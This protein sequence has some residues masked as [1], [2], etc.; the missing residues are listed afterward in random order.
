MYFKCTRWTYRQRCHAAPAR[1][2]TRENA[3]FGTEVCGASRFRPSIM[4]LCG[5]DYTD[6]NH[7]FGLYRI[8]SIYHGPSG[9]KKITTRPDKPVLWC[10]NYR[11]WSWSRC[12]TFS[13]RLNWFDGRMVR[14]YDTISKTP[15]ML[16]LHGFAKS[17]KPCCVEAP[18]GAGKVDH[19]GQLP[20]DQ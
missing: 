19:C 6:V 3:I 10:R 5:Y 12:N 2:G 7:D 17:T 11:A 16:W 14:N 18:T 20:I 13:S 1:T 15:L 4:S 9:C 8:R